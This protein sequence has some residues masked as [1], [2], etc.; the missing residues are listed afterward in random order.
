M[1]RGFYEEK[2]AA[3]KPPAADGAASRPSVPN[4]LIPE[5]AFSG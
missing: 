5:K 3:G 4:L 1:F 2:S